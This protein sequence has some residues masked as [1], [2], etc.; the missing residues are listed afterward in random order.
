MSFES[1][2]KIA[3]ESP[4]FLFWRVSVTWRRFIEKSLLPLDLTHVQFVLLATLGYLTRAK[5]MVT[6]KELAEKANCDVTMTSQVLRLLEKKGLVTRDFKSEDERA[7]YPALTKKGADILH[8]ALVVVETVDQDFF[9]S[10]KSHQKTFVRHL[11]ALD[12]NKS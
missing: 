1:Q 5:K 2:F 4:G 6:Q 8:E 12:V 7:R 9:G 11:N 10:L 3:E